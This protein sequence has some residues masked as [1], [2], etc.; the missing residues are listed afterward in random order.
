M[1][2]SLRFDI[3]QL[4]YFM[5]LFIAVFVLFMVETT[6][7]KQSNLFYT[8]RVFGLILSN[9]LL[10]IKLLLERNTYKNWLIFVSLTIILLLI[11]L[12]LRKGSEVLT[13]SYT[14]LLIISSKGIQLEK[15]V[16]FWLFEIGCL[17]LLNHFFYKTGR[18]PDVF[19]YRSSGIRY[20]LGYVFTSFSS[21]FMFHITVFY[22]FIRNKNIRYMELILL[23][24]LNY[25][26]YQKTDTKAAFAFAILQLVLA[27]VFKHITFN[28]S[29]IGFINK[30]I[31]ALSASLAYIV[32][33]LYNP[34]QPYFQVLNRLLTSRL[35]LGRLA[36]DQYGISIWGQPIKWV[37]TI[38]GIGVGESYLFVDS[39][40][41]NIGINY[42]IALLFL[43]ILGFYL[44][45]TK[46]L[47]NQFYTLTVLMISLHSIFDTQ[48]LEILYNPLLIALGLI[49]YPR[50]MGNSE[51]S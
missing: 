47:D 30:Y 24:L 36:L 10:L 48:F 1:K 51:E 46:M 22:T 8:L 7:V 33:L 9:I 41:I 44:V 40:F 31:V 26:F 42:G 50:A 38:S 34:S 17:M 39:S 49:F 15:V 27:L 25:Y 45:G 29:L 37:T 5:S 4:L 11:S 6:F 20:S 28:K 43:L 12:N 18:I 32:T 13:L 16:K 3:K 2:V 23:F 19:S 35:S 21:N 14:F